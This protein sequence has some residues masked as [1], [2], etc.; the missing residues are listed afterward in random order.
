MEY[1]F[2]ITTTT[3]K[4]KATTKLTSPMEYLFPIITTKTNL[5]LSD[6][7]SFPQH[8]RNAP[9]VSPEVTLLRH[10]SI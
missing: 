7:V 1:L 5:N 6:A 10:E 8:E 3:T 9:L 4:P 2:P